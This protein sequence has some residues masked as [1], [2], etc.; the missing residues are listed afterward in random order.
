[1]PPDTFAPVGAVGAV[2]PG[3][4]FGTDYDEDV[5]VPPLLPVLALLLLLLEPQAAANSMTSATPNV[6][7]APRVI[8]RIK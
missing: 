6:A 4:L 8:L 1:M 3:P 2:R 7:S 5:L